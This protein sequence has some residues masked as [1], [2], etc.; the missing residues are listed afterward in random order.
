MKRHY[1]FV[2]FKED[3][4]LYFKKKMIRSALLRSVICGLLTAIFFFIGANYGLFPF[5]SLTMLA[6]S[7]TAATFQQ[8]IFDLV[9]LLLLL[10]FIWE[11]IMF[12]RARNLSK[13]HILESAVTAGRFSVIL[14]NGILIQSE[15]IGTEDIAHA[16]KC[17]LVLQDKYISQSARTLFSKLQEELDSPDEKTATDAAI[18]L[19]ILQ[20]QLEKGNVKI[21]DSIKD[22][23]LQ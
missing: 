2:E 12:F 8:G 5:K 1:Q 16:K 14:P 9:L 17:L 6:I 15:D 10:S 20:E 3:K 19:E 21:I 23:Y 18:Y 7:N 11:F 13:E 4:I 22:F